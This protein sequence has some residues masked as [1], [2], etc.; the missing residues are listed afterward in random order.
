MIPCGVITFGPEIREQEI[1]QKIGCAARV[2]TEQ[3]DAESDVAPGASSFGTGQSDNTEVVAKAKKW[4]SKHRWM[5]TNGEK[6]KYAPH[7]KPEWDMKKE[8]KPSASSR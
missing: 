7:R 4:E 3:T 8:S 6:I 5:A 2:L 1:V